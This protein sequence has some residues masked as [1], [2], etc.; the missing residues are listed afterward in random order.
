MGHSDADAHSAETST[1]MT[2]FLLQ[3][4]GVAVIDGGMAT[5]LERHGADLRD[6]LWSAKCL[7]ASPHLVRAVLPLSLFL[8]LST[9]IFLCMYMSM[10]LFWLN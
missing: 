5:E 3:S 9:Y 8:T 4:G 2:D 10:F 7:I 1:F 6:P